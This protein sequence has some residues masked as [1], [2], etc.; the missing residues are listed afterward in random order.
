MKLFA[1]IANGFQ[2]FLL[3]SFILDVGLGFE[4]ISESNI[5][6]ENQN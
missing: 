1:K 6:S 2:S 4:Y 5:M 3:K